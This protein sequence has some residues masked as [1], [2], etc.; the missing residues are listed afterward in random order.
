MLATCFF[1]VRTSIVLYFNALYF[2]KYL[3][4]VKILYISAL[5]FNFTLCDQH[6]KA[7]V[8]F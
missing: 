2:T 3:G 6:K 1:E 4:K 5:R 8:A 7:A